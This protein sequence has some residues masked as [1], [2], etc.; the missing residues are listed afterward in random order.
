[1]KK[2]ILT[3]FISMGALV[4]YAQS[5]QLHV[6]FGFPN[7][8]F[9]DDDASSSKSGFAATGLNFGYKYYAPLSALENL[10]FIF[11]IDAFYNDFQSDFKDNLEDKNPNVDITFSKYIN[12]PVTVGLGYA[13][14][15]SET[16]HLY[17]E[18][19]LGTN[20]SWITPQTAEYSGNESEVTYTPEFKFCYTL[21]G[22][23]LINDKYTIGLK[24]NQLGDYKYKYKQKYTT[25]SSSN[26]SKGRIS[27]LPISLISLSAGIKF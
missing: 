23:I 17:G 13:I 11:S 21:E 22:G 2:V 1:M 6:G 9:G 4:S 25:G 3:L 8:S 19:G 27:K 7:G 10:S 15:L 5:S 12:L 14:P 16:V 26:T 24:Y 20:Y 18:G